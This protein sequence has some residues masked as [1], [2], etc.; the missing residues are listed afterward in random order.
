MPPVSRTYWRSLAQIEDRPEFR[1]ALEREF[2]EEGA[3]EL[4]DGVTR[5]EMM[6]LL[7]ASL[8]LAGTAGCRRPVEE[9]VPFVTAPEEIVPGIPRYYATTMPFRRSAYGLIIESHEGRPTKIE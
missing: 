6:M 8:S 3:S 2:L 4:P 5:R 7:G 1:T 9:I